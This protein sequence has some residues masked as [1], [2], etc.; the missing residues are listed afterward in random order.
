[1]LHVWEAKFFIIALILIMAGTGSQH[2]FGG[3]KLWSNK[4]FQLGCAQLSFCPRKI[5]TGNL[6]F[7][8]KRLIGYNLKM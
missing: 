2:H 6:F 7:N 3:S 8:K 4:P 1:M 5:C